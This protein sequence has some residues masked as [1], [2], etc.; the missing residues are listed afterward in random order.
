LQ[1]E[2]RV[3]EKEV[4]KLEYWVSHEK[5]LREAWYNMLKYGHEEND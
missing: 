4:T 5:A 3:K 1:E 2:L